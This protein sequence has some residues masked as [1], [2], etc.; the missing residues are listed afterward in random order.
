VPCGDNEVVSG[1]ACVC[2]EGYTRPSAGE[3]C[4]PVVAGLGDA[5]DT[6]LAPCAGTYSYCHVTESTSGYCTAT[7]CTSTE[8]CEQGYAC[9]R[10]TSP[11]YCRRPPIG[12]GAPCES[13]AECAGTEATL[14]D[15]R[16]T[17][18]CMVQGCSL[19]PDDCFEGWSCCDLT[20]LGVGTVCV[21][22]GECPL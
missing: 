5:C 8:E 17:K 13:N 18:T 9:E 14:C 15:T 2:V 7:G 4:V 10:D 20:A 22:E 21:P 3:A 6:T 12:L 19:S 11:S 16:F 1:G